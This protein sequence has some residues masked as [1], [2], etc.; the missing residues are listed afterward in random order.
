MEKNKHINQTFAT[1]FFF[2]RIEKKKTSVSS[3][4]MLSQSDNQDT[5]YLRY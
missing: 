4:G 3:H 2:K 5:Q 1:L